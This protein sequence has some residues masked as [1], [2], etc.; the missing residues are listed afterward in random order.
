[1]FSL[2][3]ELIVGCLASSD[4]YFINIPDENK[5]KNIYKTMLPL[6]KCG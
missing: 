5:G 2:M 4:K 1:M 3:N 6:A